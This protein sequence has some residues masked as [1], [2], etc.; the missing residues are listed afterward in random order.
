MGSSAAI[1]PL[2]AVV[3]H[4]EKIIRNASR[5]GQTIVTNP[6]TGEQFVS[7]PETRARDRARAL[8]NAA[9]QALKNLTSEPIATGDAWSAWW[10]KN[11]STFDRK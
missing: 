7:P 9:N 11:K 3:L 1:D 5:Q 4:S 10:A 2:I 8:M 6:N